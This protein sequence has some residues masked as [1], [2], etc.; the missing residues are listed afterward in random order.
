MIQ[1]LIKDQYNELIAHVSSCQ[2]A[3]RFCQ[4]DRKYNVLEGEMSY[5]VVMAFRGDTAK[6][7]RTSFAFSITPNN[8]VMENKMR[9]ALATLGTF[10]EDKALLEKPKHIIHNF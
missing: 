10:S 1:D 5:S 9:S 2:G 3:A 7:N 6:A 8:E 4:S